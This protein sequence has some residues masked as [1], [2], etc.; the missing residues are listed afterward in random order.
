MPRRPT[1]LNLSRRDWRPSVP[2]DD[3]VTN[4]AVDHCGKHGCALPYPLVFL[5]IGT[6]SDKEA[7]IALRMTEP[8]ARD[9]RHLVRTGLGPQNG[10]W[11]FRSSHLQWRDYDRREALRGS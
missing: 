6:V 9:L 1:P 7:K 3:K 4:Y 8:R 11:R 10:N 2:W 5:A